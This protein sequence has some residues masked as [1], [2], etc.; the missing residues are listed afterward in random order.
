LAAGKSFQLVA[1]IPVRA[2]HGHLARV[3]ISPSRRLILI[4]ERDQPRPF[5]R[6]EGENEEEAENNV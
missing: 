1:S 4:P 5:T 6:A 3:P 2:W